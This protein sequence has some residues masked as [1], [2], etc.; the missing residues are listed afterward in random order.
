MSAEIELKSSKISGGAPAA[1]SH[2]L[3]SLKMTGAPLTVV[4][5]KK[6]RTVMQLQIGM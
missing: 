5:I 6:I 2:A 4:Q 3:L 1:V